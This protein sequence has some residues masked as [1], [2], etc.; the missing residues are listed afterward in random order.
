M[1]S[2]NS[3]QLKFPPHFLEELSKEIRKGDPFILNSIFPKDMKPVEKEFVFTL[4][5]KYYAGIGSRNTP[6]DIINLM[7]EISAKLFSEG[8][9]CR[10]GG[11]IGADTAFEQ[12]AIL[13]GRSQHL[14]TIQVFKPNGTIREWFYSSPFKETPSKRIIRLPDDCWNLAT[15]IA[16][17]NHPVWH[18]LKG[19][20]KNLMIRNVFQILGT[21]KK[22]EY[23]TG[24]H[25][26]MNK[27]SFVLCW[28]P[29]GA[30]QNTTR[31]TGGTGMAIRV[32]NSFK[33]PV[34]NLQRRD[35]RERLERWLNES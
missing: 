11:A 35:H 10:T 14:N 19:Y 7:S 6:K 32:A 31:Q 21:V 28:T 17:Q 30:T 2:F 20:T 1:A 25:L 22:V 9:T 5:R 27:S 13:A 23:E 16:S 29:D 4:K 3:K 18:H 12:G 34:F 15:E 8:W 24:T 33:V 26:E